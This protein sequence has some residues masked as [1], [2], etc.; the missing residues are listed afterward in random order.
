MAASTVCSFPRH[1]QIARHTSHHVQ[2]REGETSVNDTAAYEHSHALRM[3]A[4]EV[5][6][7]RPC[8][9]FRHISASPR[10][11]LEQVTHSTRGQV[12]TSYSKLCKA[13]T[14]LRMHAAS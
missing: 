2:I 14:A 6:E 4:N 5:A 10:T 7:L 1:A 3:L 12:R 11:L 9:R 8:P 13:A